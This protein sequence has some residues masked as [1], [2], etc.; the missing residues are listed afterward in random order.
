M[1]VSPRL[2]MIDRRRHAISRALYG[3]LAPTRGC[4]YVCICG[5]GKRSP[6]R[7][8]DIYWRHAITE[9][10]ICHAAVLITWTTLYR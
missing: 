5:G 2:L 8:R 9:A 1:A 10:T 6:N 4:T 7:G 3:A